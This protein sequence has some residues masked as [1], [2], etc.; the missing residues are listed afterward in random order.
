MHAAP[1]AWNFTSNS[2]NHTYT[3]ATYNFTYDSAENYCQLNGGG[4]LASYAA[5]SEQK[6]V[7]QHFIKR[8]LLLPF[9]HRQYWFG[10]SSTGNTY[11]NFIWKDF[12]IQ[13]PGGALLQDK[14]N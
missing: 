7:E 14:H 13:A 4:H 9:F 3:L 8:G 5:L 6:E 1:G 12:K 11:P 10:L 2:T